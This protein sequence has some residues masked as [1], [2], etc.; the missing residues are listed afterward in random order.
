M[1]A[2]KG[3]TGE[4]I[5]KATKIFVLMLVTLAIPGMASAQDRGETAEFEK[6]A[7]ELFLGGTY[8][9]DDGTSFSTGLA[10]ERRL[11][12]K[13]GIGGLVEY[14]DGREWVLAVPVYFHPAEPWKFFLAPGLE[15]EDGEN[16]FMVRLGSSYEFEM[17]S[18]TLAPELSFDFVD[19]DVKTVFGLNFGIGF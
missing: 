3:G 11:K 9:G 10:Y 7:L 18:W 19:G 1:I 6:N 12:E 5:L 16:E 17:G 13:L 14:T 4:R 8:A 15:R 2:G